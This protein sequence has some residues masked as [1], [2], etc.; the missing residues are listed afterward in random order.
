[1]KMNMWKSAHLSGL[2]AGLSRRRFL[3]FAAVLLAAP[4]AVAAP[5]PPA[6]APGYWVLKPDELE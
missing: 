4:R 5:A 1:M 2:P 3:S 6:L